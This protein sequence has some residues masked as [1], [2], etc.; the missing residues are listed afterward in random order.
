[1]SQRP[2]PLSLP[3]SLPLYQHGCRRSL[4]VIGLLSPSAG[5]VEAVQFAGE[6]LTAVE[7]MHQAQQPEATS[8]VPLPTAPPRRWKGQAKAA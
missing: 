3:L 2:L 4:A 5:S 8:D 7:T 6:E 1:M